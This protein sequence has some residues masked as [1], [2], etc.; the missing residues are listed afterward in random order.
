M[1]IRKFQ[2]AKK[3]TVCFK[4]NCITVY[5]ETAE[6]LNFIAITAGLFIA[7]TLVTKALK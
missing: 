3:A 2:P 5:D 6:I 1:S 4:N 7:V